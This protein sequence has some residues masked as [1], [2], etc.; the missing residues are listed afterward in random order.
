MRRS[1]TAQLLNPSITDSKLL[2]VLVGRCTQQLRLGAF[3]ARRRER[4]LL[5]IGCGTSDL[6][7]TTALSTSSAYLTRLDPRSDG[8]TSASLLRV[9][10]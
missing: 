5:R 6:L 2:Y 4:V 10:R 7:W 3:S 9:P 1:T 8:S